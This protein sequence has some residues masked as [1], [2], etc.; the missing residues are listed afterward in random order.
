METPKP[1]A[2]CGASADVQVC[3]YQ[4]ELPSH[5]RHLFGLRGVPADFLKATTRA[6]VPVGPDGMAHFRVRVLPMGWSWPVHIAQA[7]HLEVLRRA[8]VAGPFLQDRVPL[9]SLE[10]GAIV[11]ACYIDNV[12]TF[13][14]CREQAETGRDSL[15][16]ALQAE[17]IRTHEEEGGDELAFLGLSL[18]DGSQCAPST[19]RFWRLALALR[20]VSVL[21]RRCSGLEMQRILDLGPRRLFGDPATRLLRHLARV[22]H[23]RAA[24]EGRAACPHLAVGDR[25]ASRLS[26]FAPAALCALGCELAPGGQ[27]GRRLNSRVRRLGEHV[28]TRC[29]RR[30][31]PLEGA[32]A[33]PGGQRLLG[34]PL[35]AGLGKGGGGHVARRGVR[36]RR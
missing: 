31:G 25:G 15:V 5:L 6:R 10:G 11:S 27:G 33:F 35:R 21:K 30:C 29:L 20:W 14:M 17:G 16:A 26:G 28:D 2:L 34:R 8:G 24:G 13:A 7:L 9:G 23:L 18:R 36:L 19:K 32:S 12:A 1:E 4:Y 3:F 22:L